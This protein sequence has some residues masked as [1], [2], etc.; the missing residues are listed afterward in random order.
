MGAGA[1]TRQ[2]PQ[3][4]REPAGAL[5]Q[6]AAPARAAP[7]GRFL[8]LPPRE[9]REHEVHIAAALAAALSTGGQAAPVTL[10]AAQ[11]DE[12]TADSLVPPGRD[13]CALY[14][15]EHECVL[16]LR[17]EGENTASA[18]AAASASLTVE[19]FGIRGGQRLSAAFLLQLLEFAAAAADCAVASPTAAPQ[20]RSPPCCSTIARI[21]NRCV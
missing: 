4:S 10:S 1:A 19:T 6:G 13:R 18:S 2:V 15:D 21:R 9:D 8:S 20:R 7:L 3:N 17:V 5:L 12:L 16:A 11:M 14:L